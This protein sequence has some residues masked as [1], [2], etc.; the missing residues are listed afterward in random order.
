[1]IGLAWSPLPV[2][3]IAYM[4]IAVIAVILV[5]RL[6][7]LSRYLHSFFHLQRINNDDDDG[8]GC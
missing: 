6:N 1:M 7:S 5:V 4:A 2:L 8:S 3:M